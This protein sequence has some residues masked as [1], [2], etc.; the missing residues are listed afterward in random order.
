VVAAA[1]EAATDEVVEADVVKVA[2]EVEALVDAE[3]LLRALY[4]QR[5][6]S[7]RRFRH[8]WHEQHCTVF[9]RQRR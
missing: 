6:H 9:A 4:W 3:N 7:H 1:E 5:K 8:G 2:D